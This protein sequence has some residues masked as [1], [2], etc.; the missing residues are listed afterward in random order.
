MSADALT[1]AAER[2][3]VLAV[4]DGSMDEGSQWMVLNA[5]W[6]QQWA[7]YVGINLMTRRPVATSTTQRPPPIDQSK[8]RDPA[9]PSIDILRPSLLEGVDYEVVPAAV[10]GL[11]LSAYASPHHRHLPPLGHLHRPQP[12]PA[13]GPLPRIPHARPTQR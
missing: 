9:F 11:L 3:R 5:D 6:L 1:A 2:D 10:A 12:A 13:R 4:Y 7:S 8:L